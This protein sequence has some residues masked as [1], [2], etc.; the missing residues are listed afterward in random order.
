MQTGQLILGDY[1]IIGGYLVGVVLIGLFFSRRQK[2][3]KEYFLA[4]GNVPWWAVGISMF[5]TAISPLSFLGVAGWV[6]MKD[7]RQAFGGTLL[8]LSL[9]LAAL[10]WIPL[11]SKLRLLSI[12]EYLELRFHPAVRAVGAAV[13]PI[14]MMF[15]VGNGLVASS[16]AFAHATGNNAVTCLVVIVLLGTV[17]TMLGGSRAVIWTDVAQFVVLSIAF[18]VIGVLLLNYFDWQ[19]Q[20]IYQIASSVKSE[21]SG[22]SHTRLISTEL[23]LAIEATIWAMIFSR[24][25]EILTFG[26]QQVI[27]QRLLASGSKRNMFKAMYMNIGVEIFWTALSVVV[28]WGLVAFYNQN[29]EAKTSIEHPDKVIAHYV[30]HYMPVL[31]R[32]VIL[33]GLLAA[34]MST[35]D[36][37]LNSISSVCTN[38]FYRRYF[39]RNRSE[40]YYL[41]AS[42][43]FTLAWGLVL[44]A[45]ALWQLRHSGQTV[46]ERF[47]RLNILISPIILCFFVLGVFFRRTNTPGA[48]IGGLTASSTAIIISGIP[49]GLLE[50]R[51]E[52]INWMWVH[53]ITTPI[54]LIVGCFASR[55]FPSPPTEKLTGLTIRQPQ[56]GTG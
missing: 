27:I 9:P 42:K 4:S 40:S 31:M 39:R 28:V 8:V 50:P 24:L 35:F 5:A 32:G 34:M 38:D 48:L 45:F 20:K 54:G 44:L 56:T 12:F 29:V 55:L 2:S 51:I 21:V 11:W 33:A 13:F 14:Q 30:V 26:T 15:W 17:Y 36:S 41:A 37:A 1:L 46:L 49:G 43:Y 18:V 47:G 7:S 19:P 6:F 23:N 52:G 22:Y 25:S 3:L 53:V 10:V 16:Q